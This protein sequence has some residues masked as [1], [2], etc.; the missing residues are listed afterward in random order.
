MILHRC[1]RG[2]DDPARGGML[3]RF[4]F[5]F[6]AVDLLSLHWGDQERVRPLGGELL[7]L[8]LEDVPQGVLS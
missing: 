3:E 7:L 4:Y 5:L 2:R 6:R 1:R 8:S